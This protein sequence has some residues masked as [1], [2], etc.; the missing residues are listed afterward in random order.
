MDEDLNVAAGWAVV[1]DWVR[2]TNRLLTD[3]Q[4]SAAQA[5][6]ALAAWQQ[7]DSVFG[8]G[9]KADAEVPSEIVALL[10]PREEARKAR[11]FKRADAIREELKVKGWVIEDTPKGP[12]PKRL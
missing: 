6:A 1:F 5:A 3:N 11:D 9:E 8:I 4:F 10:E 2:E 12:R 7:I